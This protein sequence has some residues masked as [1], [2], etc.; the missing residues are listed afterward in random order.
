MTHGRIEE[1]EA[2]L[3]KIEERARRKSGQTLE[4]I[5]RQRRRSS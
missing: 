4:P 2:E 1:A 5:R 3:A